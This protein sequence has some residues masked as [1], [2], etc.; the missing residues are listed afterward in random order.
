LRRRIHDETSRRWDCQL[1]QERIPALNALLR[2]WCG[3][4]N[5]GYVMPTY[6]VLRRYTELRLRRWL[7]RREQRYGT[8]YKRYPSAYLYQTLGLY[9]IPTRWA[10][11]PNAK[12]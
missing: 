1:P 5:H 10:A 8:G 11:V 3:Y 6:R 12:A 9:A 7:M 2:G 4:F